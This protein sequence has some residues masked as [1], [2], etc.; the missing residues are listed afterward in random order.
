M[1]KRIPRWS[2]PVLLCLLLAAPSRPAQKAQRPSRSEAQ[3]EQELVW[4]LPPAP[5]RVRWLGQITKVSDIVKKKKKKRSWIDRLAGVQEPKEHEVRLLRPYGI[6]VDSRGRIYVADGF[7]RSVLV[8]DRAARR[9]EVRGRSA[10][11]P[12]AL[13]VG[14]A[15]DAQD[16]LFVSD[17]YAHTITCFDPKGR[18]QAQFGRQEL[19]RPGGLA[20]DRKR[21]RLYVADA[22][23]HRVAVFDTETFAFQRY[24]GGPSTPGR[25]EPGRFAAPTNVAVGPRGNLYVADTWNHRVQVFDR[26]GRFL[27]AFGSHGTRPGNFV[28]PKGIAV[29]SKG[30]I[31]VVDAEFNNFQ[32][33]SPEGQP[34]LA[35]GNLGPEPGQFI[36]IAGI[37]VDE[38]DRIYTTEHLGGR[39]QIFQYLSQPDSVSEQEVSQARETRTKTSTAAIVSR[40]GGK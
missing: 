33:F 18:V 25:R 22:K 39:V 36:L 3:A 35:V 15:L 32:I 21:H 11:A 20:V 28:R 29:D 24:L 6:A 26:R 30:H 9:V 5:P 7:Q 4:P 10:R 8:F 1:A 27:R 40:Q 14:V 17:S 2:L 34:L 13:P 16:R 38:Q 23:A 19:K 37:F 12:F 31:Y